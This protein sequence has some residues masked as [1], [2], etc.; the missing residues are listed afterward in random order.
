MKKIRNILLT[1]VLVAFSFLVATAAFAADASGTWVM[2][3]TTQAG[4]GNPT[5]TLTQKGDD[6]TGTYKGQLGEAP[7]TGT[8]KGSVITLTYKI[9]AQGQDLEVVYTGTLNGNQITDGK[10]KLGTF[11]DGTFTGKKQ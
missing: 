4:T 11:G 6:I 7:V 1:P 8:V 5:F 9:N 3:V 2:E 10:V